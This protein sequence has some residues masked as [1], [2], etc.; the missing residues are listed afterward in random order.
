MVRPGIRELLVGVQFGDLPLE[1]TL[2]LKISIKL[3]L[4]PCCN[5]PGMGAGK[6]SCTTERCTVLETD[7][8][9]NSDKEVI[10]IILK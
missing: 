5:G 8:V 4:S 10:S 2:F 3:A 7:R 9:P 6:D 1:A